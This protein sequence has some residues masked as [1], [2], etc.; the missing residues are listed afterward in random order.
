MN[1]CHLILLQNEEQMS[2]KV[3]ENLEKA[4][5]NQNLLILIKKWTTF[6]RFELLKYLL[7]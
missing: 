5:P 1:L 7:R 3:R 2:L 6:S 4:S